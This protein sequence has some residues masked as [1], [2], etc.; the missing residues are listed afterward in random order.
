M[1]E[2]EGG[3]TPFAE[4]VQGEPK[5]SAAPQEEADQWYYLDPAGNVQ[6]GFCIISM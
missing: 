6:V 2:A 5:P 1:K 3:K 4:Q